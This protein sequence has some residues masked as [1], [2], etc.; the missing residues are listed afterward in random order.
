[1][2]QI[3]RE[4]HPMLMLQGVLPLIPLPPETD[5]DWGR[6]AEHGLILAAKIPALIAGHFRLGAGQSL[7][8]SDPDKTFHQNF[9]HMFNGGTASAEQVRILG[10]QF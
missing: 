6:N 7:I 1:L 2:T 10:T 3:D 8:A 4:L 9:L 5:N